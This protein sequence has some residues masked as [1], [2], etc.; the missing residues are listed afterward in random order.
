MGIFQRTINQ[1]KQ[2]K[3]F[4]RKKWEN[5]EQPINIWKDSNEPHVCLNCGK[6]YQ[7]N[8]CPRCGQSG[9]TERF[10]M[11]SVFT[12]TLE[13]WG[14]GNRGFVRNLI[15]LLYRP[16]YM[17]RDYLQCRRQAYFQ[18]VK[19][20]FILC[21]L[22]ALVLHFFSQ[23]IHG[24]VYK[25]W[26]Q[27]VVVENQVPQD[28]K[29]EYVVLNPNDTDTQK[30]LKKKLIDISNV[31]G[32]LTLDFSKWENHNKALSLLLMH[33]IFAISAMRFFR[34]S[35]KNSDM[36]L[37][38]SFFIQVFIA[39]QFLT[40]SIIYMLFVRQYDYEDYYPLPSIILAI[41]YIYD[42][43]QIFGYSFIKTAWKVFLMIIT[44][45][46]VMVTCIFLLT[47]GLWYFQ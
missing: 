40:I 21:V 15:E 26:K 2:A 11:K 5:R 25:E 37:A 20:L 6:E 30:E 35:P 17:I 8:F 12:N 38:E 13:V 24:G 29:H 9:K 46:V 27:T 34:H 23:E 3:A 28:D 1:L 33:T 7:G 45:I 18:P 44:Y 4:L 36:T 31:G 41:I 16:G 42:L 14:F 47:G 10:T 39:C 19:M 22:Y 43:R 32:K